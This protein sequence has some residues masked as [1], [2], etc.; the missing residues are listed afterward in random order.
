MFF[1][2]KSFR[3]YY[4]FFHKYDKVVISLLYESEICELLTVVNSIKRGK[5]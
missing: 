4:L 2:W 3:F 1:C 5:F